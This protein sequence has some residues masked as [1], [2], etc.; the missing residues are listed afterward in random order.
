MPPCF[1][2]PTPSKP[3]GEPY[4]PFSIPGQTIRRGTFRTMPPAAMVPPRLTSYWRAMAARG[5]RSTERSRETDAREAQDFVGARGCGR[6]AR[7]RRED[8]DRAGTRRREGAEAR[9]YPLRHN[10]RPTAARHVDAV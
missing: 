8:L 5:G 10:Q 9:G 6:H 7:H 4:S 3:A 2:A 1:S